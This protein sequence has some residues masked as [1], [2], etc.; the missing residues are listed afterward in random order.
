MDA[1]GVSFHR[2]VCGLGGAKRNELRVA[3]RYIKALKG[4]EFAKTAALPPQPYEN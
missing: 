3:A 2:N 1:H 4:W